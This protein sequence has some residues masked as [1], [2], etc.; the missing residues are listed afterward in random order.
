MFPI[1]KLSLQVADSP[2]VNNRTSAKLLTISHFDN[3][4]NN[5]SI[6]NYNLLI[7]ELDYFDSELAHDLEAVLVLIH[8]VL[9]H[10]V[11]VVPAELVL[12][13]TH[14]N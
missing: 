12:V 1:S 6:E 13:S 9:T 2:S 11:V 8:K 3:Q 4:I 5:F 10:N 14:K 7:Y